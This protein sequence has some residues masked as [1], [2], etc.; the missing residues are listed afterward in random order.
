MLFPN[1]I[2]VLILS[3]SWL[4]GRTHASASLMLFETPDI[5]LSPITFWL[6]VIRLQYYLPETIDDGSIDHF[7]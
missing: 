7:H 4:I 3:V 1:V 5:W 6:C 2:V